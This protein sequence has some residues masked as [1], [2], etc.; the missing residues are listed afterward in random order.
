MMAD[1][2]LEHGYVVRVEGH[3]DVHTK[4]ALRPPKGFAGRSFEGFMVLGM[5]ITVM[6]A[7]NAIPHLCRA[8]PGIR[9]YGDMPLLTGSGRVSD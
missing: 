2:P 6:P 3:P 8:T 7:I 1:W 9:G 4:L 5:I